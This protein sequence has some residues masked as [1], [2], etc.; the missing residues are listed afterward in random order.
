MIIIIIIMII[1]IIII[2][3]IITYNDEHFYTINEEIIYLYISYVMSIIII[4]VKQ[5]L[6]TDNNNTPLHICELHRGVK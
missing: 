6:Q 2:I 5:S 3:I 4:A 1:I